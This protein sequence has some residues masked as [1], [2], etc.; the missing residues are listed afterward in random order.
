MKSRIFLYQ[1]ERGPRPLMIESSKW[2]QALFGTFGYVLRPHRLKCEVGSGPRSLL[3]LSGVSFFLAASFFSP[4]NPLDE[5]VHAKWCSCDTRARDKAK[6][7]TSHFTSTWAPHTHWTRRSNRIGNGFGWGKFLEKIDEVVGNG[8]IGIHHQVVWPI[9]R[10]ESGN[11]CPSF[12]C[13]C[14][15]A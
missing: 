5:N 11:Q 14:W 7:D 12:S 3:L 4:H 6:K 8:S 2:R 13:C 1:R 10:G 9:S 15:S